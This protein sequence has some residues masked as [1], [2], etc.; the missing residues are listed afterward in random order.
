[1]DDAFFRLVLGP[2]NAVLVVATWGAIHAAKQVW[3]EFLTAEKSMGHRFLPLYPIWICCFFATT[4]P[5]PWVPAST[6]WAQ[7]LLLGIVLGT[8]AANFEPVAK[9]LGLSALLARKDKRP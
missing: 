5:G 6:P 8:F 1:M 3:P 4:V 9:R 2:W 7:R